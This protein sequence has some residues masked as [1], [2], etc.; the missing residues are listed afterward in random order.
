MD[1]NLALE[2]V[3]VTEA[4]AIAASKFVGKGDKNGGDKS[5][6]DAMRSRFNQIDF[7][8]IIKIGEGEKDEAPML[9]T[10]EKLGTGKGPKM[11]IALDPIEGTTPLAQGRPNSISVVV[12]GARDAFLK[13]P[14]TYMDQFCV[15]PKTACVFYIT[16]SLK[17][18]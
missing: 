12:T 9:H 8:G 17:E 18:K 13:V 1:R 3:R 10:D 15:G 5:A 4:A 7:D 14:G 11:D 16:N 2:F 6:V